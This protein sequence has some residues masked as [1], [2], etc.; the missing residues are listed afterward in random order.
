M[1][2]E[3]GLEPAWPFGLG[4][5]LPLRLSPPLAGSWSGARLHHGLAALGA[6]R[7]LSTPSPSRGLGSA[8]ART[9][10]PGRP[11][12]L[13]GYTSRI[14]SGGLNTSLSPLCIPISPLGLRAD[15][16]RQSIFVETYVPCSDRDKSRS[17]RGSSGTEDGGSQ[18]DYWSDHHLDDQVRVEWEFRATRSIGIRH[19]SGKIRLGE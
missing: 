19:T 13:T 10:R 6:R 4:I 17:E 18:V 11:P 7:L 15:V 1:V 14:S 9:P 12:S 5:F 3:A 16:T 8:L 2:P